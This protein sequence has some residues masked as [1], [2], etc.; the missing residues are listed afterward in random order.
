M[1]GVGR[2][3][4]HDRYLPQRVYHRF[5][6]YYYVTA[7]GSWKRLA[8]EYSEA[9]CA[10]AGLLGQ[11]APA[12]TVEHLIGRYDTEELTAKAAKTRQGR[13]QEFKTLTKVFGRMSAEDI[14]S[15]HVWNYWKHRGMTEQARHEIRALSALLTFARCIGARSRPNPCFGLQLPQSKPRER[16]VTDDEFLLVRDLA[17]PVIGYAMD[18]A[19]LAGMDEGT[20]RR[21]ERRHLIDAGIQFERQKTGQLQLIEWSDELRLTVQAVLRERPQIGRALICN[22]KGLPYSANGFQSQ[23]QRLMRK[24]M[25]AGLATRFHFHDLRAKS[26]SD[27]HSDQDA[28]DRLGHGDVKLTRKVYRR[29]PRRAAALRI[30]DETR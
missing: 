21:L 10:L 5:G 18:L 3:R 6:A 13:R 20:I 16:Y 22:R 28:A 29:L 15:H 19:L 23:W 17:Q 27:A 11:G 4:K 30:L 2:R 24:A 1:T 12:K 9:L 26:A 8:A 14:E 25:K 7:S